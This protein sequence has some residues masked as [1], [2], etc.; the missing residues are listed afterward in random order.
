[1]INKKRS[2]MW[3]SL[4]FGAKQSDPS[5]FSTSCFVSHKKSPKIPK[6]P[7]TEIENWLDIDLKS[8]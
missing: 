6:H 2:R 3:N 7:T 4:S 1:M 8:L 5:R